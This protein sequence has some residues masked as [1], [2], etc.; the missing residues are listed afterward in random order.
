MIKKPI[1]NLPGY[2][3]GDN[4][5]IY[6]NGKMIWP[7]E[8]SV[9]RMAFAATT[10]RGN[11]TTVSVS[12]V[13]GKAFCPEF[14]ESLRA[15]HIDGNLSNCR[16]GNLRWVPASAVTKPTPGAGRRT[17]KVTEEIVRAIRASDE[18][19]SALARQYGI[20][21]GHVSH[22]RSGRAWKHIN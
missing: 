6:K 2:E 10:D 7:F 17:A 18:G 3:V 22:I 4:G 8:T 12:R 14:K 15:Q 16:P 20:D 13:V 11:V 9:G 5:R 21:P 1:P 19:A